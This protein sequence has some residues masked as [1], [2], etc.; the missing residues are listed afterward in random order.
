[1]VRRRS[2]PEW[3]P[4][5]AYAVGIITTDGNLSKDGRHL[6]LVSKDSDLLETVKQCLGLRNSI[7][8]TSNGQGRCYHRL[9]WGDRAFYQWLLRIGLMPAKSLKLGPLAIPGEY[10]AD[11]F[12]GCID[13]DGSLTTYV[14]TYNTYKSEK[15]VYQR[16]FVALV[17]ASPDFLSWVQNSIL[18]LVGVKG[19]L[20]VRTLPG[21]SPLWKLKYAKKDSYKLLRWMYYAPNVPCLARKRAQAE[22]FLANS[23]NRSTS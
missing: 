12:R 14:D 1:M 13:G 15:Y 16:L 4:E 9:Q 5:L 17:S 19:G 22:P 10:F 7:T 8:R 6:S 11:F 2:E 18:P 23:A 20:F 21:H 3:S